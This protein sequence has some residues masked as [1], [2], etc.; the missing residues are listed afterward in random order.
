MPVNDQI[1]LRAS[2]ILDPRGRASRKGLIIIAAVLLGVQAGVAGTIYLT[3]LTLTGTASVVTECILLWLGLVA[4]SKRLHDL[5][6]GV[7]AVVWG[8]LAM[9][10]LSVATAFTVLFVLGEDAMLPGGAGYLAVAA[11]VFGPVLAATVWL[12]CA[13]GETAA[14]RFGPP[15][16]DSGLSYPTRNPRASTARPLAAAAH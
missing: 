4:V 11:S 7:S 14:N 13:P 10:L 9:L 6:Y 1:A 12:H 3:S 8:V 5:G 2:D 15:P 16:G